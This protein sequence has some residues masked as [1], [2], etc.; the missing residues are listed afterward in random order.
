MFCFGHTG[1]VPSREH[2]SS[3]VENIYWGKPI[4][5]FTTQK[6][7]SEILKV[8]YSRDRLGFHVYNG[9]VTDQGVSH[10]PEKND[11]KNNK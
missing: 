6:Q 3:Q 2:T 4:I 8:L 1:K 7:N 5:I 9:F 11:S 10:I